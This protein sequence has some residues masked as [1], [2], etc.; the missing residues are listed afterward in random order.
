MRLSF[1]IS[2]K[3]QGVGYRWFV[4]ETAARHNVSGW[5][6]NVQD[7]SVEG[8]AQ[9]GIPAIDGFLKELKAGHPWAAVDK[10]ETQEM[11]DQETPE[12]DFHIKPTA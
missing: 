10:A 9:G 3:V 1:R 7:G 11:L 8:E 4:K 6:R 2:G 5:V 12:K